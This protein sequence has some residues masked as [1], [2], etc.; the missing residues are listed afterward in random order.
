M[1]PCSMHGGH[2]GDLGNPSWVGAPPGSG[3]VLAAF[4]AQTSSLD[5]F[6]AWQEVRVSSLLSPSLSPPH[7]PILEA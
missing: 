4:R 6:W 1:Q 5:L 2:D 3:Q 7:I